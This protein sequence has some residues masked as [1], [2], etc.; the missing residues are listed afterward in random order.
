[1]MPSTTIGV[2]S[3]PRAVRLL[4]S[5]DQARPS[6]PTFAVV[7]FPSGLKRCSE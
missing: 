1:M 7:I 2:A 4:M 3:S 6:C 5:S